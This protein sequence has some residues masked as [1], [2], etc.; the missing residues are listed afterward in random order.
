MADD[1]PTHRHLADDALWQQCPDD[2]EFGAPWGAPP[3]D[4]IAEDEAH[5]GGRDWRRP[6]GIFVLAPVCGPVG[7]RILELQRRYDP[8]LAA[9][10]APHVTLVG[11][12]GVGPIEAGTSLEAVRAALEP[13]ARATPPVEVRFGAPTRFM[14]TNIVSLPLDPNGPVR[15]LYERL[16]GS[17]LPFGPARFAFTPHVTLSYFPTLDR[18]RERE[19]LA[20]RIPEPVVLARLELSLTNDPQPPRRLFELPLGG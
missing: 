3:D 14:Q 12:S 18:Q 6:K 17:G 16:R 9:A 2:D 11:S 10:H 20:V 19:L 1:R 4:D 8:K 13:I 7:E 15:A 5:G